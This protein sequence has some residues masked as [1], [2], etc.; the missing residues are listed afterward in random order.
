MP[1][2][3]RTGP[4]GMGPLSGRGAG[5]CAGYD[6]PG[7]ANPGFGRGFGMG[8]GRGFRGGGYGGGGW[9]W[10]NRYW[11]TGVPGW[12]RYGYGAPPAM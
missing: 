9:G 10:R 5:Y 7:H 3:D 12:Q 11:A 1:R 6:M 8:R 4:M 2:G